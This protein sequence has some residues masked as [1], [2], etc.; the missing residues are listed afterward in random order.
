MSE[1]RN[2]GA[3]GDGRQ[4][5]TEAIIHAIENGEGQV[6]FTRGVYRITRTIEIDLD[7]FGPISLDGCGGTARIVM[8]GQGP[9]FRLVGKHTGTGNPKTVQPRIKNVQRM[10]TIQEIEIV[11]ENP[12]ADGIELVGTMQPT[13]AGVLIHDVRHG[14]RITG[15]N[16]NVLITH[17]HVYYNTGVGIYMDELNLHQINIIGCHISYNRLGG[18]RI[19]KS[20]IRN[21]QITGNDIEYNNQRVHE[22][23]PEI[24]AEIYIDT[25][26][27]KASVAE[28][29]IVSNT[30]QATHSA[31]GCNIRILGSPDVGYRPNL[32]TISGN[33]IGSQENNVHLTECHGI[34]IS[35]NCIYSG[36]NR[37]LLVEKCTLTTIGT[38]SFRRHTPGSNAGVRL[39]E[40]TD[41]TIQGCTFMDE[42]SEGQVTGASLLELENCQRAQITGCQFVN[43][44]PC[45][46]DVVNGR[47]ISINSCMVTETREKPVGQAAIRFRGEGAD[48]RVALNTLSYPGGKALDV[49]EGAGVN[50]G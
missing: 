8:A 38:N 20:E 12:Q 11:G 47:Q 23:E 49:A 40:S 9:A 17:C 13:L 31:G 24:T 26:T 33:I 48:N 16:R 22:T 43:G 39:V 4:D 32:I 50:N 45:G 30:I 5:D 42:S 7:R 6:T 46:I 28:V 27:P 25:T 29:T 18:I 37:N 3:A 44:V 35:G 10:P 19:E 14:V 36:A 1:V 2:F 34:V 15:R 41:T 21:L